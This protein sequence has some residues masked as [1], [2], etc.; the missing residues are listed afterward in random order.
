MKWVH[1]LPPLQFSRVISIILYRFTLRRLILPHL[2]L[3]I[4]L[5]VHP[6]SD[7]SV[8]DD[9]AL[10]PHVPAGF[11]LEGGPTD[12]PNSS[13]ISHSAVCD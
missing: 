4:S 5:I 13:S 9:A 8:K 12:P 7:P 10:G 2:H 1:G 6:L 3:M 11:H